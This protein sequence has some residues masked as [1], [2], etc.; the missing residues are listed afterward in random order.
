M[1]AI[2]EVIDRNDL[3][4]GKDYQVLTISFDPSEDTQLARQKK[5]NYLAS[6]KK[7]EKAITGWQF[8]TSDSADIKR[9]TDATGFKY[10]KTGNDYVHS[11][12]LIFLSPSGKITRY[13]NGTYFLPFEFK[14]ALVEASKGQSGPTINKILQYC[15]SYDPA[16][17]QYVLNITKVAGS[18]IMLLALILFLVLAIRPVFRKKAFK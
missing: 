1:D 17:Q 13:L 9:L 5:K 7:K 11:A 3:E 10:K 14:M 12:S 16:G 2:S 4:L 8:F 18:I 15:Y 6:M